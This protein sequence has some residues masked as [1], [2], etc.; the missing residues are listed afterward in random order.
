M[1]APSGPDGARVCVRLYVC[2]TRRAPIGR[3]RDASPH[4]RGK[5]FHVSEP[6]GAPGSAR[7]PGLLERYLAPAPPALS[8]YH[9]DNLTN[10][11]RYPSVCYSCFNTYVS[12]SMTSDRDSFT[13]TRQSALH[14]LSSHVLTILTYPGSL[15]VIRTPNKRVSER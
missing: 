9:V 2:G 12:C 3:A 1:S 6:H 7:P 15:S 13:N 14:Y 4:A 11:N 8:D 5:H 10:H